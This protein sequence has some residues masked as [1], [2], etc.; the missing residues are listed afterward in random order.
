MV[1][2]DDGGW[3]MSAEL[4]VETKA[5]DELAAQCTGLRARIEEHRPSAELTPKPRMHRAG[6]DYPA[7]QRNVPFVYAF[8]GSPLFNTVSFP[9]RRLGGVSL[10]VRIGDVAHTVVDVTQLI[11]GTAGQ[12]RVSRKVVSAVAAKMGTDVD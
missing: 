5:I 8:D 11:G 10:A 3:Q 2:I 1:V 9:E 12:S 7:G 4:T 6:I